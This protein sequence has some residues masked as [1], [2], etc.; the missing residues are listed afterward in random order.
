MTQQGN[1]Y[2]RVLQQK[3]EDLRWRLLV[4]AHY[5]GVTGLSDSMALGPM[6]ELFPFVT[7]KEIQDNL[8]Y[9]EKK[10]LIDLDKGAADWRYTLTGEG[11]DCV[12][13]N[14]ECPTGIRK[15]IT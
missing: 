14:A 5:A 7:L 11:I 2:Q 15:P 10:E 13:G 4:M 8:D 6:H 12:E 9:L 3:K 1:E